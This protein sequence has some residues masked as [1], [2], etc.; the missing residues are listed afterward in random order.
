MYFEICLNNESDEIVLTVTVTVT[1]ALVWRPLLEDW[2]CITE[3]I[4]VLVSV[5]RIKQK[6]FQITTKR[7]RWLQQFQLRQQPVPCSQCSNRKGSVAGSSTCPRHD[8]VAT[9]WGVQCRSTW[10]VGNWC[11]RVRHVFRRVFQK[12]LVNQQAQLV[13]DPLSD[14]Q[15]VQLLKSWSHTVA[16][17]EIQNGVC[18]CV[19]DSLERCQCGSWKTGEH[20]V[21][22]VQMRWDKC[23]N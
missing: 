14:W 21:A 16:Q 5:N 9:R 7:V 11:Q 4:R 6:C 1:E 3:S 13:L 2:G 10:N 15:P 17:L 19:Q 20:G 12:R 8:E 22:I 23:C 18:H